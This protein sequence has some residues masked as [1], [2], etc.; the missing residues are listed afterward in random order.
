MVFC[1]ASHGQNTMGGPNRTGA[2]QSLDNTRVNRLWSN[3]AARIGT[4]DKLSTAA[5]INR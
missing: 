3:M 4:A 5:S 2:P 1:A